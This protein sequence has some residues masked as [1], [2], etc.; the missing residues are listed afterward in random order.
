MD[1]KTKEKLAALAADGQK[2][3]IGFWN[4]FKGKTVAIWQSGRKGKAICLG[5]AAV[6]LV[7]L[8]QCGGGGSGDHDSGG[9]GSGGNGGGNNET[10]ASRMSN[11][12]GEAVE[13]TGKKFADIFWKIEEDE[14]VIYKQLSAQDWEASKVKVFQATRAG[15]LVRRENCDRVVWVVTPGIR[16]EDGEILKAGY[17][18]R[19]GLYE[20]ES[21]NGAAHTVARYVQV[22]DNRSLEKIEK[23]DWAMKAEKKAQEEAWAAEEAAK[24]KANEA[25]LKAEEEA[26]KKAALKA[27]EQGAYDLDIPVKSL[28]GFKLGTPPSQVMALLQHENGTPVTDLGELIRLGDNTTYRLVKPFRLFTH[29]RVTFSDQGVGKHL[30]RVNLYAKI[31][32]NVDRKSYVTEMKSLVQLIENK[33]GIKFD[34][35][36]AWEY[37]KESITIERFDESWPGYHGDVLSL[38]FEAWNEIRDLDEK[39]KRGPK[40]SFKLKEDDG[41]DDL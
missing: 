40:K 10:P 39:A 36:Y 2:K 1:N 29:V 17:Y 23:V 34:W 41:A 38:H 19:R 26:R 15:N 20:Y 33:F 3:A 7:L 37:D 16:H 8:M 13:Y 25:R 4:L 11:D 24:K 18:V 6:V 32:E 9:S 21:A 22:T 35:N 28:C 31:D 27:A 12:S 5:V 30:S 14:G